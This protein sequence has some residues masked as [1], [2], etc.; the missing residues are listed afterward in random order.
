LTIYI[1]TSAFLKLYVT[2]VGSV[3]VQGWRAAASHLGSSALAYVEARAALARRRRARSLSPSE[4]RAV[5]QDLDVDWQHYLS[6]QPGAAVLSEAVQLVDKHGLRGYDAIHLASAIFLRRRLEET[7]AFA[8]WD[9]ELDAA[10]G[11]EGFDVLRRR[12]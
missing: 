11:R 7:I 5:V 10:A 6:I 1:D 2:E 9:D 12:R 4:H 3:T 8:S